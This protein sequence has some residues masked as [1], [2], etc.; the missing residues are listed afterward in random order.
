M[1]VTIDPTN[2]SDRI[3]LNEVFGDG[4]YSDIGGASYNFYSGRKD[5]NRIVDIGGNFG[6]FVLY[7]NW[8][9]PEAHI[10]VYEPDPYLLY[11][12][13]Q[14]NYLGGKVF[15]HNKAVWSIDGQHRFYQYNDSGLSS[16]VHDK[17][18]VDGTDPLM[19]VEVDTLALDS[20]IGK[21]ID[22]LKID[23]EGA[24]YEIL[25]NSKKLDKVKF[26]IGEWHENNSTYKTDCLMEYLERH[27][28]KVVWSKN[29]KIK[30][31]GY[32]TADRDG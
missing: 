3:I 4:V 2:E 18:F 26:I 20:I 21:G 23:C 29:D 24:E 17:N 8:V 22:I 11:S 9:Y 32:F 19:I 12:N 14:A 31:V 15:V 27:G 1:R 28:F 7:A 25:Y 13:I 16:L 30:N 10:D 6:A 5:V